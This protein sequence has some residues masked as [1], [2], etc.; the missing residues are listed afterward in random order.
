[1]PKLEIS[2][3]HD[4]YARAGEC[5][6]CT[7]MDGAERTYLLS[8][9]HSRVM[10][11][12]VRVKTNEVGFCH[13]HLEKLYHG[14]NKLGLGLVMLTHVQKKLPELRS[15]LEAAVRAAAGRDVTRKVRETIDALAAYE[16]SCFICGLLSQD[17]ERYAWTILYL[18]R[19]D[20]EFPAVLRASRGFCLPHFSVV[21]KAA[22][23]S[24]RADR[25]SQWLRE[26]VPLLTGSLEE[27]GSDLVAFT[28]LAQAGNASLGSDRERSALV[29]TLQKLS[30]SV[31][32]LT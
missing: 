5:P 8:F 23:A 2:K 18:W 14:E 25:L 31:Q 28:Q 9:Q 16:G 27:L 4:A 32:P 13:R 20:P 19:K 24:L 15:A 10:E 29:R 26:V 11:P 17:L 1:M 12:T 22:A 30:G 6:L 7:L 21:L 3:V